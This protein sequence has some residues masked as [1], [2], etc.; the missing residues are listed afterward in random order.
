MMMLKLLLTASFISSVHVAQ[1][2]FEIC[3]LGLE[4]SPRASQEKFQIYLN[5]VVRNAVSLALRDYEKYRQRTG[6]FRV[7]S[8]TETTGAKLQTLSLFQSKLHILCDVLAFL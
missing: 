8:L 1:K 7:T 4:G 5:L 6:Q 2:V 3:L